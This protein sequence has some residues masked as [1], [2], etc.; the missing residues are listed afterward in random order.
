MDQFE[1]DGK[2]CPRLQVLPVRVW[3]HL[4]MS[5]MIANMT[6]IVMNMAKEKCEMMI[7]WLKNRRLRAIVQY[8]F[9]TTEYKL[10]SEKS[11]KIWS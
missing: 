2:V 6:P 11:R 8:S 5:H 9:N 1:E 3:L 10:Y 4:F 7:A